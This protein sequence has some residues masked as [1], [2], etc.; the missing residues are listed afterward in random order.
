MIVSFVEE[1]MPVVFVVSVLVICTG[2][3]VVG[4][5]KVDGWPTA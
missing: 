2:C 4:E 3:C 1:E 5:F